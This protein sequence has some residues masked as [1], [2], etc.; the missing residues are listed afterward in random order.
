MAMNALLLL[1]IQEISGRMS[2]NRSRKAS[3][4]KDLLATLQSSREAQLKFLSGDDDEVNFA[5][6][7]LSAPCIANLL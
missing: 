5:L 7:N 4:E 3:L 6:V 2:E 1:R